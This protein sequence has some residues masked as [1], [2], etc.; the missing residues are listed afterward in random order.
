MHILGCLEVG[1]GWGFEALHAAGVEKTMADGISRRE[2]EANVRTFRP[3][4]AWHRQVLGPEGVALC[5]GVLAARSS[6][7]WLRRR[8]TELIS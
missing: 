4:V 1:S 2:S 5:S 7:S 8:L 6:A 3:D